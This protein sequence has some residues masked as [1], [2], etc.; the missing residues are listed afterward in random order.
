MAKHKYIETPEKMWCNIKG[1]DGYMVSNYGE[2]I[3]YRNTCSKELLD[4]PKV[5]K[6]S[7]ITTHC[8]KKYNRVIINKKQYYIH[9][10]VGIHFIDNPNNKPQINHIDNNSQNN[11]ITNLEWATNSENQIHRFK[12]V[13]KYSGFGLYVYKCRNSFRV[14][15]RGIINKCFKTLQEAQSVAKQY[16]ESR[17]TTQ[18]E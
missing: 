7:T 4:K 6:Q 5:L 1:H 15:K 9:R 8:G 10:L 11:L 2:V 16:Y 12:Q 13:G 17:E 14:E 18:Y 3:S